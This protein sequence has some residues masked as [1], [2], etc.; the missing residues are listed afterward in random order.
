M[1]RQREWQK[2]TIGLYCWISHSRGISEWNSRCRGV[3]RDKSQTHYYHIQSVLPLYLDS[4]VF[5]FDS[6]IFVLHFWHCIIRFLLLLLCKVSRCSISWRS[7][8]PFLRICC[9]FPWTWNLLILLFSIT[10]RNVTV[11]FLFSYSLKFVWVLITGNVTIF[12][13]WRGNGFSCFIVWLIWRLIAITCIYKGENY[14]ESISF[15]FC[16]YAI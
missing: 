9:K 10:K 4:R 11:R 16:F 13:S 7:L 14:I 15:V 1:A 3:Q 2:N 5:A 12:C 8:F 6:I